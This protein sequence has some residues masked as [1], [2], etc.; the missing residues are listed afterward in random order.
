MSIVDLRC[1]NSVTIAT[2]DRIAQ[3][4]QRNGVPV[5]DGEHND[6]KMKGF[7]YARGKTCENSEQF[8]SFTI[9][10]CSKK[11]GRL[12]DVWTSSCKGRLYVWNGLL[13]M[14]KCIRVFSPEKEEFKIADILAFIKIID[15]R[16]AEGIEEVVEEVKAEVNVRVKR[17]KV[18]E[19]EEVE[20]VKEE[21]KVV[22]IDM[23]GVLVDFAGCLPKIPDTI[24]KEYEGRFDEIPG[25]F[26]LMEP[27]PGAIDS[28][29]TLSQSYDVYI[30]STAPW[31]NPSSWADKLLWVQKYLPIAK[32]R[33][34]LSHNK[35][36]NKGDYL[37]DDR[38]KNGADKFEG[39]LIRFGSSEFPDWSAVMKKLS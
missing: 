19:T 4:F 22:Y 37:I 27:M 26:G 36:L 35:N 20:E 18:K 14:K 9:I 21:T 5:Y 24:K 6:S 1:T 32:K 23:D 17:T 25:I 34:I 31:E 11:D 3:F 12:Y 33:L 10:Y 13:R 16:E 15:D 29:N 7:L 38:Y 30:L 8:Y 2:Y 39:E 28:F